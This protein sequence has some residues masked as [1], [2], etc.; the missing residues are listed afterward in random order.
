[1]QLVQIQLG[2]FPFAAAGVLGLV[3][4]RLP[5]WLPDV[6]LHGLRVGGA[7]VSLRFRRG[8]D[9][10]AEHEV[11]DRTGRLRVIEVPPPADASAGGEPLHDRLV[12]W[13]V[14]HMPG[15]TARA[16]RI[17]IGVER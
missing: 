2:I 6:T 10:E 13:G 17:A 5:T 8:D 9:G 1:V 7:T 12:R 14:G 16:L 15:A 11:L 3:R 4:P